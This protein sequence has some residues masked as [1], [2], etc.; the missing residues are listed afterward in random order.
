M[1]GTVVVLL[2][3]NDLKYSGLSKCENKTKLNIP[4][5]IILSLIILIS[6]A[7]VGY[8]DVSSGRNHTRVIIN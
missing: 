1:P 3:Y 4:F 5:N 6:A 8:V 2:L 7:L